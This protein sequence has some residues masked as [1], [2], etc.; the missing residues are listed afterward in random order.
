LI[1]FTGK[2]DRREVVGLLNVLVSRSILEAIYETGRCMDIRY[3]EKGGKSLEESII[4]PFLQ[5]RLLGPQGRL[6]LFVK[7]LRPGCDTH[8]IYTLHV[9]L[10][11]T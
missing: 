10:H 4:Q 1:T 3:G 5:L 11:L 7:R 6:G 9:T 2:K 8:T